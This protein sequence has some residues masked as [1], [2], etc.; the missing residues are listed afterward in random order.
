VE[1]PISAAEDGNILLKAK[2]LEGE[3]KGILEEMNS[4][5]T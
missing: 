2:Y 5:M 1:G 4:H 3:P